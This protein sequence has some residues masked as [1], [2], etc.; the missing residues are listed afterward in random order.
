[1]FHVFLAER[2][3]E[4]EFVGRW[5]VWWDLDNYIGTMKPNLSAFFIIQFSILRLD[6]GTSQAQQNQQN[7][8]VLHLFITDIYT[9]PR[10]ITNRCWLNS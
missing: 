4:V 5:V 9:W 8:E 1:M 3:I 7:Y 10:V 6:E 2:C